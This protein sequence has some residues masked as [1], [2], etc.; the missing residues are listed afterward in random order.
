[1]DI[2]GAASSFSSGITSAQKQFNSIF[3]QPTAIMNQL[4]D[5]S[6]LIG[7]T[8]DYS[9]EMKSPEEL[10]V[11]M[12][13]GSADGIT[14]AAAG[15]FY[16]AS[17]LGYGQSVGEF[18]GLQSQSP[19]GL[20]FFVKVAD[21]TKMGVACSNGEAMYEYVSTIPTGIPGP[22]GDQLAEEMGGIRLQGLAPGIVND[23]TD[24]LNPAPFFS[25]AIGSGFPKCKQLT[26][27]V[28][29]YNGD[30][31][32]RNPNI[33]RKWIQEQVKDCPPNIGEGKKCAT[34]WVFDKWISADEYNN[35]R[36]PK[37]KEN[38]GNKPIPKKTSKGNKIENFQS[39]A[40]PVGGSPLAAGILFAALFVGLVAFT[41]TRK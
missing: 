28:G 23:A 4:P 40:A 20:N 31:K 1:M 3:K 9:G 32:S 33:T 12:N 8:Y 27:P 22:L 30:L 26:A 2:Q 6:S 39:L 37:K 18:P 24:A 5:A 19:M 36:N 35:E 16:Y 38:K 17:A 15:V 41:A 10:G 13:D 14:N 25:A 34:H 11:V 29:D 7:P 21:P